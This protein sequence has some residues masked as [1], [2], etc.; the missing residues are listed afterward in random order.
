MS[1]AEIAPLQRTCR[2]GHG[3]LNAIPGAWLLNP[4]KMPGQAPQG[5]LQSFHEY[6]QFAVLL[7]SCPVCGY[8]EMADFPAPDQRTT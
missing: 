8:I 2:Y 7:H 4:A 3:N 6:V 5:L 1:A